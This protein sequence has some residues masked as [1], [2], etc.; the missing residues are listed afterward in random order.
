MP[1][2]SYELESC[3]EKRNALQMIHKIK[4]LK[5]LKEIEVRY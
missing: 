3:H 4:N 1:A 5:Y 2:L